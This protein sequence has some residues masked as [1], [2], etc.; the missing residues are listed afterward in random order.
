MVT[1]VSIRRASQLKINPSQN[2]HCLKLPTLIRYI[3]ARNAFAEDL[4]PAQKMHVLR[5]SL[6]YL[7]IETFFF[8]CGSSVCFRVKLIIYIMKPFYRL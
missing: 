6:T 7:K 4:L 8:F 3:L 1:F 2:F 5:P